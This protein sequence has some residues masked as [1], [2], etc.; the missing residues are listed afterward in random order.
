[1][2]R[3][4]M[5]MVARKRLQDG[6]VVQVSAK[7][8]DIEA[9]VDGDLLDHVEL[10][11]VEAVVVPRVQQ[12]GVK[13]VKAVLPARG[14][15]CLEGEPAANPLGRGGVPNRPARLSRVHLRQREVAPRHL[16]LPLGLD[17]GEQKRRPV[18]VRTVVVVEDLDLDGH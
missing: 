7:S 12:G 3:D 1:M 14:F 8:I 9:G 5:L 2:R 15:C 18:H 13:C 11:D 6:R 4:S 17:V 10:V 16:R